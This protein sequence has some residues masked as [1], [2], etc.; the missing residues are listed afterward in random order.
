MT[1]YDNRTQGVIES[2]GSF[3]LTD[4]AVCEEIIFKAS[5]IV[6]SDLI[7]DGKISALFDLIV[8]GNLQA[9]ELDVKGRFVCT[10][11]VEVSG[12]ISVQNDIWADNIKAESIEAH[13]RIVVQNIDTDNITADGSIVVGNILAVE[14]IA[15]SS[16]N[17]LCGETAYGAGRVIANA[18][19]TG[20][21]L[22]L[23]DGEEAV[24]SPNKYSPSANQGT[25]PVSS[26]KSF[27]D[28][29]AVGKSEYAPHGNYSGYLELLSSCSCDDNSKVKIT[30]W[31]TVLGKAEAACLGGL[32]GY[33]DISILIWLA[34]IVD[35]AY[36]KEWDTV[37]SLFETVKDHFSNLITQDKMNVGCVI[38]SYAEWLQALV[39][40]NQHGSVLDKI[41]YNT[42]FELIISN[43]GLKAKFVSERL[44]EKGWEAYAE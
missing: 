24:V 19:I 28:M 34:E 4:F 42:A 13:D 3:I 7:C 21:A 31:S 8:F 12:T 36:F 35:S 5:Y 16:K 41:T 22:D 40:L 25:L 11:K 15:Q 30:R 32:S 10:G 20:E 39:I 29:I 26:I 2:N 23:D 43:L 38:E 6:A 17:I 33:T 44:N 9:E 37:K 27:G 18:I 14:K 1:T